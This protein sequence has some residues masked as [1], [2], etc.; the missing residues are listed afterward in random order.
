M[1]ANKVFSVE[2]IHKSLKVLGQTPDYKEGTYERKVE[3]IAE[4]VK[5]DYKNV[6]C[7]A[8][9]QTSLVHL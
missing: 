3:L 9:N 7:K 2:D 1:Q 4:L 5:S 8:V 6:I